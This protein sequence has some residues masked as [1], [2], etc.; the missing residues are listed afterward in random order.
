MY[1]FKEGQTTMIVPG[2]AGDLSLERTHT[3]TYTHTHTRTTVI[4]E[5]HGNQNG[6]SVIENSGYFALVLRKYCVK[7]EIERS[8]SR[9]MT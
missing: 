2:S 6:A 7:R 3:H 9:L 4:I 5:V 1:Q 8:G